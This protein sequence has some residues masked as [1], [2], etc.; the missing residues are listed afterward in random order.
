M[1][2]T[3]KSIGYTVGK[4]W[5]YAKLGGYVKDLEEAKSR[6]TFTTYFD[7]ELSQTQIDYLLDQFQSFYA[8]G[9]ESVGGETAEGDV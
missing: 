9:F 4:D 7:R 5:G 2:I 3:F 6:F 1:K 8:N